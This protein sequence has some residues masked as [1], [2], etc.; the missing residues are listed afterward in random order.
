VKCLVTGGG[1]FLGLEI[2][3]L[4]RE[5]GDE[6]ISASRSSH[7]EVLE[8]GAQCVELELNDSAALLGA[9]RGVDVVFHTAAKAGVWG[10]RA[11]YW[12]TNVDGTASVIAQCRRAQ[13]PKL[14]FSSSPSVCFDGQ[15]HLRASNDLPHATHFLAEYPRSKAAAERLV[16]TANDKQG[17]S[18]V[19]L[20]PHLIIG[21]RDPHLVP[22][23]MA[24]ARAGKLSQV[25]DGRNEVTLCPV[26]SAAHAH[27]LAADTLRPHAPHAGRAYFI[28]QEE[29]VLLWPWIASLL[30]AA[31][32]A[33]TRRKLS[34]AFA[35][36]LGAL[37]EIAWR[38]LPLSGEPPMTRFLAA[39]LS[40]S[41]SY[42]MNPARRDFGYREQVSLE[43]ANAAI[44]AALPRAK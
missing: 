30:A 22:R 27:V 32:V 10:S 13:V 37:C 29:P 14:V 21:A 15:D 39:Q 7:A 16:L 24:R 23:L 19:A 35:Y 28:G 3:R 20:R 6:V 40:S 25:G 44:V 4:L 17:L 9:L 42:D 41:H 1:G 26:Q 5:R 34:A 31:G 38:S 43:K 8:L 36:R 2:V 12:R 18:T 11:E 33:P